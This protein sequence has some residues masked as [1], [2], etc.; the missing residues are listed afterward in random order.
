MPKT[1]IRAGQ[2]RSLVKIQAG[3]DVVDTAGGVTLQYSDVPTNA[4]VWAQVAPFGSGA[5]EVITAEAV[6]TTSMFHVTMRYRTD[7][8][9]KG[10]LIQLHPEVP[11]P[12][13][14]ILSVTDPD[15]RRNRLEL[16]CES[17]RSLEEE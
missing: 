16:V 15:G 5:G 14:A 7:I 6:R 10:R 17:G 9:E 3:A 13:L 2:L 4:V 8:N 12:V 11:N 1:R